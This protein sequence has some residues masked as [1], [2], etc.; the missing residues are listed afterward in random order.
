MRSDVPP[1]VQTTRR[2]LGLL[3]LPFAK[4]K[5]F[6]NTSAE[7]HLYDD[8]YLGGKFVGKRV[9]C[10]D[11]PLAQ[12]LQEPQ[13]QY[14]LKHD[15]LVPVLMVTDVIGAK[16]DPALYPIIEIFTPY[17]ERG[18]I[19]DAMHRGE[20]F[21]VSEAIDIAR[22]SALG[23]AELHNNG[24]VHRDIKPGNIFLCGGEEVAK[25]GDLGEAALLEHGKVQGINS[26]VPWT[27]PEQI[28]KGTATPRSDLFSLGMT[29]FEMVNGQYDYDAYDVG[30][31]NKRLTKGWN[32]MGPADLKHLPTVP[33]RLRTLVDKLIKTDPSARLGSAHA[34]ISALDDIPRIEWR[35]VTDEAE[36]KRW[37]GRYLG[38]TRRYA[39]S[40]RWRPKLK[41]WELTGERK[42]TAWQ[43]ALDDIRVPAL[44][45]SDVYKHF[46]RMIGIA[47]RDA[48]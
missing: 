36:E 33:K 6:Y 18:S 47:A 44:E 24:I 11:R 46:D 23:L 19:F 28:C 38:S 34:V 41:V 15:N 1:D 39:V 3:T 27:A 22:A 21:T 17:Y 42:V 48:K 29:L 7:V 20:T 2:D 32:A 10:L 14:K 26:P 12:R 9:D 16:V 5:T 8:K 37:E 31:W 35:A 25:V 45:A 30:D 13:L 40:A 43:R 4:L